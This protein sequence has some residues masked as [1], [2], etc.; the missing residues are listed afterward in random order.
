MNDRMVENLPFGVLL[1]SEVFEDCNKHACLLLACQRQ[2]II[3]R[4]LLDFSP[5]KQLDGQDSAK[6]LQHYKKAA[7]AGAPQLFQWRGQRK[8]GY[9]IDLEF[10]MKAIED[11][12]R[13]VLLLSMHDISEQKKTEESLRDSEARFRSIFEYATV[14]MAIIS[15]QGELMQSNPANSRILGFTQEELRKKPVTS[16]THPADR[17]KTDLYYKE[18]KAGQREYYDLDKRYIRKDGSIVWGHAT[19]ALVYDAHRK[20]IYIIAMLQDITERKQAEDKIRTLNRE[21]EDRVAERTRELQLSNRELEAFTYSVSHDLRAPLRAIDGFSEALLE[22][23]SDKLDDEGRTYLRYLQEG[24]R[25]MN[26]LIE[27]LLKLSR[28]T[29]GELLKERVDLSAL[30]ETV[31]GELRSADTEHRVTF[32]VARNMQVDADPR[33]LKVVIENL[34][35]NA[36]KYSNQE[37]EARIEVGTTERDG[38]TVFFVKDNGAGFDMTFAD[39]LFLP[40]QRLHRADEFAGTGIGLATVERIVHRHGGRIW[41]ESSAGEGACFYF[42]LGGEN[43]QRQNCTPETP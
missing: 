36:W 28:S 21:L 29:R 23:Y 4:S 16:F 5:A 2:Q 20:P 30:V 27:G 39:K 9:L 26:E 18:L 8:D 11:E 37:E 35:G 42:T 32:Q 22:D 38:E 14:G 24:S 25:D 13:N 3:G 12:G 43:H 41:A 7:L 40:F 19:G 33:L 17:V 6:V 31:G 10:S 34:L 15:L 1:M